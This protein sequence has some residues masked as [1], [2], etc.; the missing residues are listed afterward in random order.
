M[1]PTPDVTAWLA[2]VL[3]AVLD[4]VPPA[5]PGEPDPPD[6]VRARLEAC[7]LTRQ[8]AGPPSREVLLLAWG[9]RH[10]PGWDPAWRPSPRSTT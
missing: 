7:I 6:L 8:P 3:A 9:W 5:G 10:L 2:A 1:T 4:E